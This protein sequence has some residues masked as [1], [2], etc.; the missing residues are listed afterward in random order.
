MN[1]DYRGLTVVVTG[2]GRGI[3]RDHV[4]TLSKLGMNVVVNDL[5]R[6]AA[7]DTVAEVA[8]EGGQAIA[9]V[10]DAA[11]PRHADELVAAAVDGFG[12]LNGLVINAGVHRVNWIEDTPHDEWDALMHVHLKGTFSLTKSALGYWRKPSTDD[13]TGS[14]R[15]IVCTTSQS[16]L[17]GVPATVA[18]N[19]AK[20]GVASF[21][22]AAGR[23]LARHGVRVNGIAP[24]GLTRMSDDLV[25]RFQSIGLVPLG[26]TAEDIVRGRSGRPLR[27]EDCSALVPWLIGRRSAQ[28]T[29][30][31]FEISSEEI[32]IVDGWSRGA[33]SE[34]EQGWTVDSAATAAESLVL[35]NSGRTH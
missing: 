23:E 8:R 22:L 11:D 14:P 1:D 15:S 6:E 33:A 2:G 27:S 7:E 12:G 16:G 29:S 18:Y 32:V 20:G 4:R 17:Y 34:S 21:V 30:T 5:D 10:G 3:G 9:L 28:V 25:E 19:V 26:M 35:A 24:R 31:V 13:A